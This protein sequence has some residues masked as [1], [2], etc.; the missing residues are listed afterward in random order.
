MAK[1]H[2]LTKGGQT[3]Y[4]ATTTDA[5]VHP[6]TRKNLTEELAE[7]NGNIGNLVI[8]KYS[9]GDFNGAG[10][11][12]P[13]DPNWVASD[14]I[15][16]SGSFYLMVDRD[17]IEIK[18]N[19]FKG[20]GTTRE[21]ID[22][23]TPGTILENKSNAIRVAIKYKNGSLLDDILK[24]TKLSL[25]CGLNKRIIALEQEI[26]T[27]QKN[28]A[29]LNY[30][31]TIMSSSNPKGILYQ[32]ERYVL[33]GNR[34]FK[35]SVSNILPNNVY[36][37]TFSSPQGFFKK[38]IAT[39]IQDGGSPVVYS[40]T[41]PTEF[42]KIYNI[43]YESKSMSPLSINIDTFLPE[44]EEY[45]SNLSLNVYEEYNAYRTNTSE[46]LN[47]VRVLSS[48]DFNENI[49]MKIDEDKVYSY[50]SFRFVGGRIYELSI[51]S[52]I[53]LVYGTVGIT[54]DEGA[55]IEQIYSEDTTTWVLK[56]IKPSS[57]FNSSVYIW[58]KNHLSQNNDTSI[59]LKISDVTEQ[60]MLKQNASEIEKIK[61]Q[62]SLKIGYK[63]DIIVAASDSSERDKALADL[64]CTGINDE[65][66]IQTLIDGISRERTTPIAFTEDGD[67]NGAGELVPGD[68]NWVAS[69][70]LPCHGWFFIE[71]NS[72]KYIMK[73]NIT[74]KGGSK[75]NIDDY[76]NG[77]ITWNSAET[78]R[79]GLS[80]RDGS[81][82]DEALKAVAY[83]IVLDAVQ[84]RSLNVLFMNGN[85]SI[86]SYHKG[87]D[88]KLY[89]ICLCGRN[90][91]VDYLR[92]TAAHSENI[93]CDNYGK[94]YNGVRFNISDKLSN[95][96]TDLNTEISIFGALHVN[97][98]MN[99]SKWMP[100]IQ[101]ENIYISVPNQRKPFLGIN[102]AN[103]FTSIITDC[104]LE[105][106]DHRLFSQE[107]DA[108]FNK[109]LVGVRFADTSNFGT[110][111]RIT[112]MIV[113]HFYE[114][115]QTRGDHYLVCD[116]RAWGCWYGITFGNVKNENPDSDDDY[117]YS[118]E[119][120]NTF[121]NLTLEKCR[122]LGLFTYNGKE[123]EEQYPYAINNINIISL[124][125]ETYFTSGPYKGE[126]SYP[127]KEISVGA[128]GGEINSDISYYVFEKGYGKRF[129][130]ISS[131]LKKWGDTSERP[132]PINPMQEYYDTSLNKM[133]FSDGENWRDYNG[134]IV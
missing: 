3:I 33:Y 68:P 130:C 12:V 11:L 131:K 22:N 25:V 118:G 123:S 4:P 14:W 101:M 85:Y 95:S 89:C 125:T 119:H 55:N 41:M 13:E 29:N 100:E 8:S 46:L 15:R 96:I 105:V 71:Y 113:N 20:D 36:R 39:V 90:K 37:I 132:S 17:D 133:I 27:I 86:D 48:C 16:C 58:S 109:K 44:G 93:E 62:K 134:N 81:P 57:T 47:T 63:C 102:L 107:F 19:L 94:S 82:R 18:V 66:Q 34:S 52:D 60:E 40:Q 91:S 42:G 112:G 83:K 72:D 120:S 116:C 115:F 26:P 78:V 30:S 75:I 97:E 23:Y 117:K 21:N 28:S 80:Y 67:F 124:Q 38:I 106:R 77:V 110:R 92:L 65:R 32:D 98:G 45:N 87:I 126:N 99:F 61:T 10:E 70:W 5:V 76:K 2:K 104:T 114:G 108:E 50:S 122:Y 84:N 129:K 121:I 103:C 43:L 1:I 128:W 111:N 127:F 31:N 64:V 51:K 6:T 54:D 69:E 73:L 9:N 56:K 24:E 59:I 88:G 35:I 74:P 53:N 49:V 7:L 79:V